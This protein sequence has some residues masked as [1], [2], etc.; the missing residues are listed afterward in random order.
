MSGSRYPVEWIANASE[1]LAGLADRPWT[2]FVV[3]LTVNTLAQPYAGIAHDARLYSGQVLNRVEDGAYADDL[4]FRFGSQDQYSLFSHL[5][6]PLVNALGLPLA[7]FVIYLLSKSLLIYGMMR[8]VLTLVPSRAAATITLIYCMA[9]PLHYAGQHMLRIQEYFVT[10]RLLACALVLIGLDWMLRGVLVLPG[11]VIVLAVLI[12][13]LMAFGGLLIWANYHLWKLAG[14]K[15]LIAAAVGAIALAAVVL[16]VEPLGQSCFGAMD[17]D[18]RE[19]IVHASSFNFASQWHRGDWWFLAFQLA[20]LCV[21]V[22]RYRAIDAAKTRFPGSCCCLVTL[23]GCH[24]RFSPGGQ[25]AIRVALA[26]PTLSRLVDARLS[27]HR[28]G[29]LAQQGLVQANRRLLSQLPA[30]CRCWPICAGPTAL[31]RSA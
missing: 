5:A 13:P 12:H 27:A 6:A 17:D 18:W 23:A 1:A 20:I 14:I 24:G 10:P 3:L 15:A 26:G 2:L 7:F 8:L 22:W 16:S 28:A 11:L 4:F 30:A 31:P 25:P 9:S 29:G 21:A 19:T